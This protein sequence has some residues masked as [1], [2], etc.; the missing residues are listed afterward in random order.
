MSL[1]RFEGRVVEVLERRQ[2]SL[3]PCETKM[4][5][6]VSSDCGSSW[7]RIDMMTL[8]V[9]TWTKVSYWMG[10]AGE[11]WLEARLQYKFED[12]AE[13][14]NKSQNIESDHL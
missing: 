1:R 6:P 10:D 12:R 7:K 3:M 14:N 2:R 8:K 4:T 9:M 5:S 13:I 11:T